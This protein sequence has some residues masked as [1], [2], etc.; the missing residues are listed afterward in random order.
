[1]D[2]QEVTPKPALPNKQAQRN[3][4]LSHDTGEVARSNPY[5]IQPFHIWIIRQAGDHFPG[6]KEWLPLSATRVSPDQHCGGL[7]STTLASFP[8]SQEMTP[9]HPTFLP[10]I[11]KQLLNWGCCPRITSELRMFQAELRSELT[12]VLPGTACSALNPSLVLGSCKAQLLDTW[13]LPRALHNSTWFR[14]HSGQAC[15][16]WWQCQVHKTVHAFLSEHLGNLKKIHSGQLSCSVFASEV[17]R[18][19]SCTVLHR[20]GSEQ[21]LLCGEVVWEVVTKSTLLPLA[22]F[23]DF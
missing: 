8:L 13:A 19:N 9:F 3:I 21:R 6:Y 11:G 5:F 23:R 2:G 17:R 14:F 15:W 20:A 12:L 1:M 10:L 7:G 16:N 18:W 4:L 22:S